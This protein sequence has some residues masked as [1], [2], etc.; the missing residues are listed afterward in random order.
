MMGN[1]T[2]ARTL[3]IAVTLGAAFALCVLA[4]A[5]ALPDPAAW[6]PLD[7]GSGSAVRDAMGGKPGQV[8]GAQWV[9]GNGAATLD[10]DGMTNFIDADDDLATQIH[11]GPLSLSVWCRTN[12]RQQQYVLT[13]FGWSI[14]LA[15]DGRAHFETR[16]GDNSR[17]EDIASAEP[18]P[19]NEWFH[20]ASTYDADSGRTA[21][22]VNGVK[23]A[24]GQRAQGFGGIFRS[25]M[26]IGAWTG[27]HFCD[28]L[29][30]DVRIYRAVLSDEQAA[31]VFAERPA[32]V[33]ADL[34]S[35]QRRFSI[36]LHQHTYSG[37][38]GVDVAFRNLGDPLTAPAVKLELLRR[39]DGTIVTARPA[40][41][42]SEIGRA[43][44]RFA[45]A[46][47]P[48]GDYQ[49]RAQ[50]V[51][52]GEAV[53]GGASTAEWSKSQAQQPWWVDSDEGRELKLLDPW[54][55]MSVAEGPTGGARVSCW[56][57]SYDINGMPFPVG[58]QSA[59]RELLAAPIRA[60]A[61]TADGEVT[62]TTLASVLM[63]QSPERVRLRTS[64]SGNG[65][66][67]SALLTLEYDGMLRADCSLSS[68]TATMLQSLSVDIPFAAAD[69]TLYYYFPDL[70]GSWEAHQPGAVP[71]AGVS[72][73]FN[74]TVWLGNEERGLQWF[75]ESAHNW[76]PADPAGAIQI[77]RDGGQTVLRLNV[78]GEPV[79]LDPASESSELAGEAPVSKLT[80]TFGL[81]ATP[82]KPRFPD[83]WDY[84]STTLF[85]P[86]YSEAEPGPDGRSTLDKMAQ[87]GVRTLSLMDWTDILCYNEPTEP[88]KLR[89]FV[90]ECHKRGIK[91]LVYFGFQV[92]DAAPEFERYFEDAV[93]W[94]EPRPYSY[95][96]NLDN[97]PPKP[98]Q[99]VYR[100]CYQ[101]LWQDFIVAGTA[102]LIDEYDIDGV[103]LDGTAM[104]L[105]CH[106]SHH[107]CGYIDEAGLWHPTHPVFEGRE[108]LR[109]LYHVIKSRKPD[110]QINLH[111]SSF[112]VPPCAAWVTSLWDGEQLSTTPGRLMPERMPLDYFR[113]EFMGH[114]WGLAQEFLEYV[115]PYP[116]QTE[117]GLTLLH[118]VPLRPYGTEDQLPFAAAIWRLLDDFGREEA[119]WLPYWSNGDYV[120]VAPTEAKASI[121]LH[122]RNGALL[123][124]DNYQ[125]EPADV[126]VSLE[127]A[128]LKLGKA[129]TATDGLSGEAV[130]IADGTITL[131]LSATGW[132]TIWVKPGG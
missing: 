35:P 10:F 83:A 1:P 77:I 120:D 46:E 13:R 45:T 3:R 127:L 16:A 95:V 110:G 19:L 104:P 5:Q 80:Y 56:G 49:L 89:H 132:K 121:Y 91:V 18:V 85:T 52:N 125:N 25:K 37:S 22:F 47:L 102:K 68:R 93:N 31:A 44:E 101:S 53:P 118:D 61:R 48:D 2:H 70:S 17:W 113:T 28:G 73:A 103:Y 100:V 86:V 65:L 112:M 107:G 76:R 11:E 42:L 20:L 54:T 64:A 84:R 7:D 129:P 81:Q 98:V 122:P 55:P 23:V 108:T 59:G 12:S 87:A 38:L 4:G 72:M 21:L 60:I 96:Y 119:Q 26:L 32:A 109:R 6:Y 88:E 79:R 39:V 115:L 99:T 117:W 51:S 90:A 116:Y 33:V 97:Y 78:I 30:S 57:R 9:A 24:E 58:V 130:P 128:A 82:V 92:S 67:L 62:W 36:R 15:P 50:V 124:I 105:A 40:V 66:D 94:S 114:Q 126:T 123:V 74:P 27:A 41:P 69:A 75:A 43:Q 63:D 29:L 106:N 8:V 71:D 34:R 131:S 111:N 14:Y